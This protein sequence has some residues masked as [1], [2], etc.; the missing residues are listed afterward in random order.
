MRKVLIAAG[1]LALTLGTASTASALDC[2]R[3]FHSAQAAIAKAE[4][5]MKAMKNKEQMVLV[6]TLIDDAK[7]LLESGKH[8]HTKPAAGV[9]DHARA[10]TKSRSAVGYAEAAVLLAESAK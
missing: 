5:A 7:A 9:Y 6:H 2:P 1:A 8:N 10:V 4:A 3:S